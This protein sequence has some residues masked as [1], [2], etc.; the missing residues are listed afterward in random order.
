MTE[1]RILQNILGANERIAA[2][3]RQRL[4]SAGVFALNLMASPGAGKTSLILR[5]IERLRQG[6]R[7]AVVEGDIASTIDADRIAGQGVTALQ[8]N[9]GGACHL[10]ANMVGR[11]L[12]A[13]PLGEIDLLIVENVGNLVCPAEFDL[14]EECRVMLASVAEGHDKPQKYP[15]M[16]SEVEAVV[17]NKIDLLPYSDFDLE[18]FRRAVH[19]LNPKAAIIE[20]S[21]RTGEGIEAWTDWLL[22]RLAAGQSRTDESEA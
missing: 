5:T 10:D 3:N 11:A 22:A 19:G 2:E 4:R 6:P 7:L 17:L 1:I 12:E 21:C 8:I 9:T 14:G 13:L 16:F 20:V 18:A 15:L